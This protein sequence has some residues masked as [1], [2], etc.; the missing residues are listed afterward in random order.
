MLFL[1]LNSCNTSFF[2]RSV[3]LVF[4]STTSRNCQGVYFCAFFRNFI[5]TRSSNAVATPCKI[6]IIL[7]N[8]LRL[9]YAHSGPYIMWH[10]CRFHFTSFCV[11]MVGVLLSA[12][13][14]E[15]R[16]SPAAFRSS[17]ISRKTSLGLKDTHTHTLTHED[18]MIISS[19]SRFP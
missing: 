17:V 18:C 6:C 8:L 1:F 12:G 10:W 16:V 5:Q 7:Q 14:T 19:T 9:L 15:L 3:Q 11:R 4:S 13:N 2:T